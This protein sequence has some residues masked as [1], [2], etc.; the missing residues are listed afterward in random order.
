MVVKEAGSKSATIKWETPLNNGGSEIIGYVIEKKLEFM[1]KWEKVISIDASNLEYVL[2]NLKDKSDYLFRVSAENAV[3]V[4][5]PATTEV[6]KLKSH[7]S[8]HY[9]LKK[10][11][12]RSIKIFHFLAVPT[13]PTAPLEMRTIGPNALI[14]EWGAP[15]S[16]G[17]MKMQ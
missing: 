2:Q 1:P 9:N 5:V 12:S 6:V 11:Y 14:I 4:S 17:G 10:N 15:E 16:D 3:G 7:A 8:M 13:P